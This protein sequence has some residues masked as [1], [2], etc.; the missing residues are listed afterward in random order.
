M[1]SSA[2]AS[3][4]RSRVEMFKEFSEESFQRLL[5]GS[6]VTTFEVNEAILEFGEE[7]PFLGILL[8][9]QAEASNVDDAGQRQRA[10]LIEPGEVIGEMELLT[11]EKARAD[12]IGLSRCTVLLI[13]QALFAV[14]I[15][16]HPPAIQCLS[17]TMSGRLTAMLYN[18]RSSGTA[19]ASFR[20]ADDPYGLKLHTSEA[21]KLLVIN[22]GSSSLKYNLFDTA[23]EANNVRGQV[24][25]IGQPCMIHTCRRGKD[26]TQRELPGGSH[27]EAFAAMIDGLLQGPAPAL[28]SLKELTAVG[29]RVVHGGAQFTQSTVITDAVLEGIAAVSR[30]A[31]LHNPINLLG[32]REARSAFPGVPQVAVFDTAFHHTLPP[33]AYLYGL[34]YEY[35]DKGIRRYGFHGPSHLYVGLKAAEFLSRPFN[36]LELVTCH[37]GNGAS[38]CAI[39]HGRSVDTSMGLT[40]LEGLIMGTRAGSFDPAILI[41]LMRAEGLGPDQLDRLINQESG[42]KGISGISN[43]MREIERAAEQGHHRALLAVKSFAY[44]VRK[45][46]GAYT[47]AM[48]G[49]DALVFTGGIGQGSAGMRSL[50]C[51][52]LGCLG[53]TIDEAKNHDACGSETTCDIACDGGRVRILVIPT[54]EERMIA[55]ETLRAIGSEYV[56]GI[57]RLKKHISIPIEVS[58]HH[59]HLSAAHVEAL[60]GAGHALTPE[61]GL[62]QPGQFACAEKVNLVGPKGRVERVRVLGPARKQSQVEISMTEQFKLGIQPPVR[63]SGDLENTP[64]ITLEGPAGSVALD[65]G[66]I[67]AMRH[68][69]MSAAEA[70]DFGLHDKHLVRVQVGGDRELVFGDVLVRVS[71]DYRLAMHID[72]DEANAAGIASGLTGWIEAVQTRN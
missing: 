64:G 55:R 26:Q 33:Y 62:S 5:T 17:R 19:A 57:V 48:A 2:I 25:R 32:I 34:P 37:L 4:L 3:F 42:L 49:I 15:L 58:A 53:I 52:T 41:H 39:D 12:V 47:A 24:E 54:D 1:D 71:P 61:S 23:D 13:P 35:C 8:E 30:L 51:Q 68:I 18:E 14:L 6:R 66:V 63:E 67:C 46:I 45:C 22:C 40:P 16:T 20:A 28:R 43:D 29:H 9:G 59:V 69:H 72:T 65:K 38:V 36:E 7:V 10:G 11:G 21:V 70:T 44:Q 56:T 27:K 50:A 60:F 31:P